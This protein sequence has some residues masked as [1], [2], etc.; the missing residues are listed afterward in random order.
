MNG[1]QAG[2]PGLNPVMVASVFYYCQNVYYVFVHQEAKFS[3]ASNIVFQIIEQI[4]L[5]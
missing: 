2:G 5:K 3:D 4:Y 1:L